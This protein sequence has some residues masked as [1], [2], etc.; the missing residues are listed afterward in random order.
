MSSPHFSVIIPAANEEHFVHRAI[1]SVRA[2]EVPAEI[3]VAV[4]GSRDKTADEARAEGARVVEFSELLGASRARNEG[5]RIATGDMLVFLDADSTLG[6]RTL[7]TTERRVGARS[8]GTVRGRPDNKKIRYKLFFL[9]KNTLHRF[10][11][12]HGV[13]GGLLFFDAALF[14]EIGGFDDSLKVNEF[15]DIIARA[16]HAGG[17]YRYIRSCTA[18]TSMRRFERQGFVRSL[19]FWTAV[20]L[21]GRGSK[22]GRRYVAS[23]DELF[24]SMYEITGDM[25]RS[26]GLRGEESTP[27]LA[28][29]ETPEPARLP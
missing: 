26:L 29:E 22:L 27:A 10:G 6:P 28:R 16:R 24:D 1:R 20:W 2:Q 17:R 3:I 21:A 9:W 13:L 5:A 19:L 18:E 23:H 8:F 4:N 7:A 14:R 12:F 25:A 11:L 15:A